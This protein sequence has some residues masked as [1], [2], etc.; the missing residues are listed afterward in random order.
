MIDGAPFF[1]IVTPCLN[2]AGTIAHAIESVLA[3]D[4]PAFEHL[5]IDGGSTDG[6]REIFARYPHLHVVSEPDRNLYDAINKG[7]RLVRGDVVG[8]LNSDDVYAPGAFA[9]VAPMFGDPGIELAIGGAEMF[10]SLDG[11]DTVTRRFTSSRAIALREA[12]AIGNVTLINGCF[13]RP[14]LHER[15]GL[16]DDRFPLAADKDFWMRL[17]LGH[18]EHR[19]VPVVLY[20]YLSHP[21]SL[22][23]ADIDM[24]DKLSVHLLALSR[25]RF[26]ECRPG[27]PAHAAYRRWHAWA[28]G[29]R[30]V[31][32]LR[33]GQVSEAARTGRDGWWADAAWPFRFLA[34]VPVHWRDRGVGRDFTDP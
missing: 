23:F 19:L 28:V 27:T 29:Y 25:T 10:T 24:R 26:A 16:F 32:Y 9:A 18:P 20:R 17:V 22:T 11:R 8:L 6:T 1:S 7:L 34:R 33:L 31:Q 12:N 5:V 21:G 3:Q 15:I 4:Y 2:R 14:S 30:V 13:W